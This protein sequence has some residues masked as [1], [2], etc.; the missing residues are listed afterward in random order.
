MAE[1]CATRE[2]ILAN[3]LL[4]SDLCH[5]SIAEISFLYMQKRPKKERC[6][7]VKLSVSNKG[8][9]KPLFLFSIIS[10]RKDAFKA[11]AK[12]K[13]R[14]ISVFSPITTEQ[15]VELGLDVL[16]DRIKEFLH[17]KKEE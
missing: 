12:K 9:I 5:E 11:I 17:A 2:G 3:E 1:A 14:A 4:V 8:K 7:S 15:G 13:C 6:Q 16:R 10:D